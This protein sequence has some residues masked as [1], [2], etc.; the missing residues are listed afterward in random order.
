MK[1]QNNPLLNS[2]IF[3]S[4]CFLIYNYWNEIGLFLIENILVIDLSAVL[5]VG[6]T[7]S[8]SIVAKKTFLT[9]VKK[10]GYK[11][12]F[13][14][15]LWVIIKRFLI[16]QVSNYFKKHS[17]ERFKN[18]F[19]EVLK[20]KANEVKNTTF[21]RKIAAFFS[22]LLGGTFLYYILT[23]YIGKIIIGL[24]QK[25]FYVL[26]LFIGKFIT[27]IFGLS[28]FIFT[29]IMQIFFV[30][31]IINY[32]EKFWIVKF[33]YSV[34]TFIFRKILNI[35]DFIFGTKIHLNLIKFSRKIDEYFASILD[36]NFSFY[37]VIQRRRDR[38]IN[39][40]E[41]ISIQRERYILKKREIGKS[42]FKKY[43][44]KVLK[45]YLRKERTWKEKREEF[46][47]KREN[48][49]SLLNKKKKKFKRDSKLLLPNKKYKKPY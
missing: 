9:I 22:F 23:T 15:I 44:D 24:L 26:I 46:Y 40:V 2:I 11:K 45:K 16:E 20:L 32:I 7:A 21:A 5:I 8:S 39:A 4:F 25:V 49:T 43:Y 42:N 27:F 17:F 3:F 35:F 34:V 1:K 41:H 13:V 33:F 48:R 14:S 30:I 47:L 28:L 19:F 31:K 36:K 38:Y 29:S 10:I 37:E 18:N 12:F 6:K